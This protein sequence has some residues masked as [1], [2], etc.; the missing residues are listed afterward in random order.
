MTSM[1]VCQHAFS[2]KQTLTAPTS[3]Q[4]YKLYG[5]NGETGDADQRSRVAKSSRENGRGPRI[6][7]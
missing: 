7:R 2:G 5:K 1:P 6:S 3:K 4:E